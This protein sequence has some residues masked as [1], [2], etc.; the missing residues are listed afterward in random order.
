MKQIPIKL[1][2]VG[3]MYTEPV[4]VEEDNLLV[5][6]GIAIRKKDVERLIS[7]GI[8]MVHTDG[9]MIPPGSKVSIRPGGRAGNVPKLPS[10]PSLADAP[11]NQETYRVYTGL[12]EKLKV[13][14]KDITAGNP[15]EARIIDGIISRLLQVIRE[16]REVIIGYILSGAVKDHDLAKSSVNTAILSCLITMAFKLPNHKLLQ[17]VSG[18]LLH[19]VGMLRLPWEILEKKGGLTEDELQCMRTHP[20][21]SYRIVC[22]E[23]KYPEAVGMVALQ[24]HEHWDGTGYPRQMA[25][26]HIDSGARIVSVADAFEAMV[27]QKPYRSSLIGYQAMKNLLA[28]NSRRFD[29][30]VLKAFIKTMGFYPIGSIVLL[31]NGAIARVTEVRTD[32]PLRPKICLLVSAAGKVYPQNKGEVIDLLTEK[33]LFITRAVDPK[34]LTKQRE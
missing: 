24:H 26:T 28:D 15:V 11:E 5:P 31:N 12:I 13:I 10:V 21:L 27:S 30:N 14:F 18:A 19:D 4:Y 32:T 25:G 6:A 17:I 9:V 16:K 8:D 33:T 20:L 2:Q 22:K 34:E 29:P 3:S 1:L 7:W 23:L